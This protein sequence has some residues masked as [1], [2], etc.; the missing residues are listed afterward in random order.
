MVGRLI[1]L[2]QFLT[3]RNELDSY[4]EELLPLL[5]ELVSNTCTHH[6]L[7]PRLVFPLSVRVKESGYEANKVQRT[8]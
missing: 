6:T 4:C 3:F 7:V 1:S 2:T 5:Q 8:N